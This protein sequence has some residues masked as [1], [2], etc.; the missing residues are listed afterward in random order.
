M[1]L[2]MNLNDSLLPRCWGVSPEVHDHLHCFE[3]VQLQVGMTAPVSQLSEWSLEVQ[4][5]VYSEKS[6]GV[7]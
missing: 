2:P 4:L 5:F 1:V 3:R 7:M 6:S